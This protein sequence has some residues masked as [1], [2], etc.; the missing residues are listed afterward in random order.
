LVVLLAPALRQPVAIRAAPSAHAAGVVNVTDT[1]HLHLVGESGSLIAEEGYATGQLP[2]TVKARFDIG[3]NV[4]VYYTI[5]PR[6]GGSITGHGRAA[7]HSSERYSTFGGTLLVSRGTGRFAHAR[8]SGGLYGAI[9]RRSYAVTVQTT[10]K[11]SY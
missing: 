11:L 6:S 1:A 8:G 10:G 4:T 9:E 3:A 7:L 5:Y 2:G